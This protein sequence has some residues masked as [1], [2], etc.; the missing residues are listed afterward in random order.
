MSK[1]LNLFLVSLV[2]VFVFSVFFSSSLVHA[3][4]GNLNIS[5]QYST[6]GGGSYFTGSPTI[7]AGSSV[8]IKT[9]NL[10]TSGSGNVNGKIR[11]LCP[12]G[13]TGLTCDNFFSNTTQGGGPFVI[14]TIYGVNYS[15]AHGGFAMMPNI[16]Y[17]TEMNF[18]TTTSTPAGTYTVSF[19]LL[20]NPVNMITPSDI[21]LVTPDTTC[22]FPPCMNPVVASMNITVVAPAAV[23]TVTSPTATSITSTSATLGATV[24]S[25]GSPASISAR[26][27]CWGTSFDPITNCVAEGGTTTGIF[28]HSRTGLPASTLIYYRGYATNTT[29]TGY[30]VSGSFTTSAAATAPTGVTTSPVTS[31]TTTSAVSGGTIGSNGGSPVT[32]S[33]ITWSTSANPVYTPGN[34]TTQRTDGWATGG[35]WVSAGMGTS[36]TTPLISN[37]TYHVRAYAVNAIGITYGNDV[38]FLTSASATPVI[39]SMSINPTSGTANVVNPS[40]SWTAINSTSCT[41]TNDWTTN[42]VKPVSSGGESQGVLTVVKTYI[43]TLTCTNGTETSAPESRTVMVG[44][45]TSASLS[46]DQISIFSGNS[47]ILTW[48]SNPLTAC[49]GTNFNTSG[50]ASN[51]SPGVT[52]S[53]T[54]TTTYSVTCGTATSAPVTV[55]VKKTPTIIE[56]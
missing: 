56:N 48:S 55:T 15:T 36:P 18:Y 19:A 47:T 25:L 20:E 17:P 43:Y 31:I 52:V 10:W 11:G 38:S 22:Q 23:P 50:A 4:S 9:T 21:N 13:V 37:T 26:G 30:S 33:G 44:A 2:G 5:L 24:T 51:L 12:P 53:P 42:G 45:A 46:A 40:I 3:M 7:N 6:N 41:A 1:K 8:R 49:T 54:V 34:T 32:V 35:P 28:T 14:Y 29:G 39:T 27:T 16:N